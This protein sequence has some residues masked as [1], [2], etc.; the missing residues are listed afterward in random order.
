[1]STVF[2]FTYTLNSE[3]SQN[4]VL[5]NAI[6][7]TAKKEYEPTS[8]FF[9]DESQLSS[10]VVANYTTDA[11]GPV[12]GSLTTKYRTTSK[13]RAT[14]TDPVKVMAICNGQVLIQPQTGDATK[15][16]LILKPSNTYSPLKIKYFI[17]RGVNKADLIGNNILKPLVNEGTGQPTFLAKLWKQYIA[18]NSTLIDPNT[19]A[20]LPLP[21]EFPSFLIGYDETQSDNTLIENYFTKKD[22]NISY[23][24]PLCTAGEHLGNFTGEI[25]LDI[26]LDHGDY[27]LQ[28][29]EELFKFDLKF[30]REKEHIF[31]TTAIP[32]STP[33]K[34]KRYK[35]YI[36]QF[37]DAAAFW[38]SHMECGTIKTIATDSSTDATIKKGLKTNNDIFTKIVNKYQTQNKIYVYVQGE[39]NRSYNYYDSTR[40]VFGFSSTGQLNETEASGWPIIIEELTVTA[41]TPPKYKKGISFNLE[42]NIDTR[43]PEQ[44]RHVTV[45]VIS[46]NNNTSHYPL[47]EK[48][49]NPITPATVPA[50]LTNKTAPIT[51]ILQVNETKSCATFLI[52]YGNLKQEFPL[53]NYYN[54]LFPANFNTNFLLP[55]AEIEN[56]NLWATYDK[57]RMINLD[58]VVDI[59]ASIQ[60]KVVFDNGKESKDSGAAVPRKTRRLYMAIL[61]RNSIHEV[62]YDRLNIDTITAGIA[63]STTTREQYALN[64]YNNTDFSVFKGTFEDGLDTINSLSLIHKDS[65]LKKNSFFHLGITDEEYNTLMYNQINARGTIQ[66]ATTVTQNLPLE[67]D[68]VFF[69][70]E[71]DLTFTNRNVQKF[72]VGFRFEDA[73][74]NISTLF[75]TVTNEVFVYTVDG[76]YFFSKEYSAYQEYVV[77][78]STYIRNYEEKIGFDNIESTSNKRYEDWFIEKDINMK[79]K[80]DTFINALSQ[81]DN[82]AN[83]YNNVKTLVENSALSIWNQA[84]STVQANSNANPDDR[85][86]YWARLKMQVALKSHP[87]FGGGNNAKDLDNLILL[88]EEKSRNYT[89]VINAPVGTNKILIT[90]FDPFQL[91]NDIE[92]WNPSGIAILSLHGKLINNTYIQTMI[93]PVRYKDFDKGYVEKY[94]FP[95]IANVKMIITVSQGRYRFDIERFASKFRTKTSTDNLNIKNTNHIFYL[96][97]GNKIEQTSLSKIPEFLETTLPIAH[98]IPG[99]LGNNRVVYN[100][101]YQ[102][103]ISSLQYSSANSG[104]NNLSAPAIGEIALNGSGGTY[105]SNE[106]FFRV[107]VLRNH[108]NLNDNLKSGHLHVPIL[109]VNNYSLAAN[110]IVETTKILKDA[111]QSL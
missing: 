109:D 48:P 105:L 16:N 45:D 84:I 36:H 79:N 110:F 68:N 51:T 6:A 99:T 85:P 30:A 96:P 106:I 18:Y 87:Y 9:V 31:D 11:F 53:K 33:V 2:D 93:F 3:T 102:S 90:G 1:M 49:V 8:H 80:V 67:A 52:L 27:Q 111:I 26:V 62:E 37:M 98:M 101:E 10:T 12:T 82:N 41:S 65:S 32:S 5:N 83:F 23:Q 73:T 61:K 74:G 54:N 57:S 43:I 72:K 71:E 63:K 91:E 81:I 75:P 86:L 107:A 60:N 7:A 58:A 59:G 64:V 56:M 66:T 20:P 14:V 35:E 39:N 76:F 28:N 34:I 40:K 50:F 44:E 100:Q 88:F 97:N 15:V 94:I 24:I 47:L 92:Q 95:H 69:H 29:Q 42:Y 4:E 55:N 13:I 104:I 70:L 17:Y 19:K 22:I 78:D 38:G 21:T 89:S 46:P 77:T 103:N 108:L 25:G